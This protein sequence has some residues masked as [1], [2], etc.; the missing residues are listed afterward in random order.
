MEPRRSHDRLTYVLIAV[1]VVM[2]IEIIYLVIQNRILKRVIAD[3]MQYFHTLTRDD[4]VPSF[5]AQDINGDEVTVNYAPGEP[6]TVLLWFGSTCSSCESNI[7]FWIRMHRSHASDALRFLGIFIGGPAAAREYVSERR[8]E[9]PVLCATDRY[10][11]DV[12]RGHI[13]PQTM[14]IAPD[15]VIEGVWP[16]ILSRDDEVGILQELDAIGP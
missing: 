12:Y 16:G 13:L 9:F 1:V 4:V 10:L 3:P 7:D 2:G 15:G 6:H 8:I 11:V 5:S 14:L